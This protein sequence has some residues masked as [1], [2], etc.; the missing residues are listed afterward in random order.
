MWVCLGEFMSYMICLPKVMPMV[1]LSFQAYDYQY[2]DYK[3]NHYPVYI[4]ECNIMIM[5]SPHLQECQPSFVLHNFQ[6]YEQ[7]TLHGDHVL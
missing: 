6:N 5:L 2:V 1:M 3:H 4:C 7:H